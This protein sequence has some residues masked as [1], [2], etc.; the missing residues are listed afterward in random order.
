MTMIRIGERVFSPGHTFTFFVA[1]LLGTGV[2]MTKRLAITSVA[3][4]FLS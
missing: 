1:E 2:R 3:T 4:V